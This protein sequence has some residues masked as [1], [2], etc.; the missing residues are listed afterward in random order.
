MLNKEVDEWDETPVERARHI[1]P[2][3][4]GGRVRRAQRNTAEGPWNGGKQVRDHE[5]VVPVM[6]VGRGDIGPATTSEGPEQAP[7]GDEAGEL[8]AWPARQEVPEGDENESRTW[9][10]LSVFNWVSIGEEQA[11]KGRRTGGHGDEEL[12]EG[13]LGVSIANCRGDGGKPLFRVSEPLILDDLV[14]VERN[15]DDECAEEGG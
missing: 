7:E 9:R 14:V 12:E 6:V 15:A 5:D 1:F 8:M 11:T 4:D 10:K 2:V 3:F 13:S